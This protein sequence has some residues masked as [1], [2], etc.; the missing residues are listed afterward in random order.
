MSRK[1][2]FFSVETFSLIKTLVAQ[3]VP[4]EEIADRVGCK[5]GTLRVRC[6]QHRIS[7]RRST[8]PLAASKRSGAATLVVP[9][10]EDVSLDL[11]RHADKRGLSEATLAAALLEAIANDNLYN[12]VLDHD[13]RRR[14]RRS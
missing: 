12:A 10:A 7:L 14:L 1:R 11:Q 3:G 13:V 2:S 9:L 5:L 8:I 6:S 4:A